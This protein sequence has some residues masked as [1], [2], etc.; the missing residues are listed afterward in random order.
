LGKNGGILRTNR[1]KKNNQNKEEKKERD[2]GW[3]VQRKNTRKKNEF[4]LNTKKKQ[5]GK[6]TGGGRKD[7]GYR[8]DRVWGGG[9][10]LR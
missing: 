4:D 1:P 6:P 3:E 2:G 7:Q 10:L 9:D 5:T 8:G